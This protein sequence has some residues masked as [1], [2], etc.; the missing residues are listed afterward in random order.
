[1]ELRRQRITE[2][3]RAGLRNR[4][5]DE[6]RVPEARADALLDAWAITAKERGLEPGQGAYWQ[7]GEEW[8]RERAER[9]STDPG[10]PRR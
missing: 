7:E 1:M 5:R 9:R 8:I 2:A 4:V 6:W 10:E 3:Q